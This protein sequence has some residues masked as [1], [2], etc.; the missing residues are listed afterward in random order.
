MSTVY[1]YR[2][3][4][5]ELTDKRHAWEFKLIS[6][7]GISDICCLF[8][9]FWTK[10]IMSMTVNCWVCVIKGLFAFFC[11]GKLKQKIYLIRFCC[12]YWMSKYCS[13][14]FFMWLSQWADN[15]KAILR[16]VLKGWILLLKRWRL[17]D[18]EIFHSFWDI[19]TELQNAVQ[20]V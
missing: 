2:Y 13:L 19:H 10:M 3:K 8:C 15:F 12:C 4:L 20:H 1:K 16:L 7:K 14:I 5:K 18:H 11:W 9:L 17:A 6:W